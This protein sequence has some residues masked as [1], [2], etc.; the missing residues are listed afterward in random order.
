MPVTSDTVQSWLDAYVD[1]WRSN[2]VAKI[3]ALFTADVVYRF[4]PF[5]KP[6]I[7]RDAVVAAWLDVDDPPGSWQADYQVWAVSEDRAAATGRT[8]YASG[9]IFHNV[10]LLRF[11]DGA[12]CEYTEWFVE[13]P[14]E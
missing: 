3:G 1:A 7:G 9:A 13:E 6:L 4:R 8:T 5:E 11:R 2:E 10:F 14:A 12:C